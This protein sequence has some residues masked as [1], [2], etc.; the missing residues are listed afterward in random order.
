MSR[1]NGV[2][3]VKW[4]SQISHK[5]RKRKNRKQ[6]WV[7]TIGRHGKPIRQPD[8]DLNLHYSN[9]EPSEKTP[10][11]ST[12]TTKWK[13]TTIFGNRYYIGKLKKSG[14]V[15]PIRQA[16]GD[17][18]HAWL[19]SP[20]RVWEKYHRFVP[21]PPENHTELSFSN[22][23]QVINVINSEFRLSLLLRSYPRLEWTKQQF[24]FLL[25]NE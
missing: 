20:S 13:V 9:A 3:G 19:H 14:W 4:S 22:E 17:P 5:K 10:Y 12:N 25:Q 6:N 16:E 11:S 18:P 8:L 15:G 21:Q 23:G 1:R 7:V 24:V 2:L